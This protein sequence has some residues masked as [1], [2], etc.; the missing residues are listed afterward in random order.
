MTKILAVLCKSSGDQGTAVDDIRQA[1]TAQNLS[2]TISSVKTPPEISKLITKPKIRDYDLIA[3]YGGDGSVLHAAKALHGSNKPLIILPGGTANVLAKHY[4]MDLDLHDIFA[5]IARGT[6]VIERADIASVNDAPFML[7][8]HTGFWTKAILD[9]PRNLKKQ[10]G[11][12]AYGLEALRH[13]SQAK[14]F[15][16][17]YALNSQP[18]VSTRAYTVLIANQGH[19]KLAGVPLFP[20]QYAPGMVQ[21]ALIKDIRFS[22][23]LWWLVVKAISGKSLSHIITIHRAKK[24][25]I[26][27]TPKRALLDDGPHELVSPTEILGGQQHVRLVVPP[28]LQS[29]SLAML[30]R[31]VRD[32]Y[33]VM[34]Q[35]LRVLVFNAHPM[36]KYSHVAPNVYLGGKYP[37]SAYTLFRE[38][39]VTGVISMRTSKSPPAPEGITVLNLPTR[40][41]SPPSISDLEKG[42]QFAEEQIS[43]GGSVYIHCRLG[44][45]RGPSM[46]AAYLIS[47]GYTAD[48]A[49]RLLRR[50]RPF[51]RPNRDQ[52]KRLSE[53]QDK[54]AK[55]DKKSSQ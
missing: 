10:L 22:R 54:F 1:A 36:L 35:R 13:K 32:W 42:I 47:K 49:I 4:G 5:M 6:Y 34:S 21:M 15:A 39:G 7:D 19:H 55:R 30:G 52:M 45:G 31:R 53:L 26:F 2:I 14:P 12:V 16:F 51:V 28:K 37:I 8:M 27:K 23:L 20:N 48:E 3:V 46:A 41:W 9:T 38:W 11:E 29:T 25:T 43:G 18:E 17:S 33:H 40:D 24:I 44:E 50:N